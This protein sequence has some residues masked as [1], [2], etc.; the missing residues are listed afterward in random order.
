MNFNEESLKRH[1]Q[2]GGKLSV[3]SKMPIET[4]DDLSVVYTPGVA[5]PCRVIADNK[6]EVYNYTLKKNT[7]AV[8]TDGSAVLGLGNIGAEASIPVMEGKAALFKKFADVD[9]FPI[10]LNTQDVDEIVETVKRIEPVFGGINLEDISAPRCVEVEERL[11]KELS[12]PVFHDDQHGTAIVVLAALINALRVVNKKKEDVKVVVNGAGAAGAAI[13]NMLYK[14]GFENI[15]VCDLQGIL[16]TSNT[17]SSEHQKKLTLFTNR[18]NLE[19]TLEKALN[20]AD[21]FVGV[22]APNLLTKEM[23]ESMAKDSIVLAM[24]NPTPEIMPELAKKGGA[25]IVGTGRSDYENQ[26]NNVLAFPGIFRGALD[27][28]A[29]E[30][31][32]KMKL[33]AA[34]AIADLQEDCLDEN[35]ILPNALDERVVKAVSEAVYN[36]AILD[37]E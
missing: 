30:I 20:N 17:D 35:H 23:I 37:K 25:K 34:K 5:A 18:E 7:V 29:S 22:S 26:V 2:Y 15:L 32:D 21:I 10:C 31:S 36:Q 6:E 24:A 16:N 13:T 9:A 11:K 8:I 4:R 3:D 28:R 27:A 14:Y 33:V 19:G 1:K 12:I